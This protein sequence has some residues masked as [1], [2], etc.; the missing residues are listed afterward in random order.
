MDL[1]KNQKMR[2]ASSLLDSIGTVVVSN[3]N[4]LESME[5]LLTLSGANAIKIVRKS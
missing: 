4:V 5:D 2:Q 1:K 3:K